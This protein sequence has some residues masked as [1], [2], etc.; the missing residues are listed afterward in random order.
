MNRETNEEIE[1]EEDEAKGGLRPAVIIRLLFY[2]AAM[3]ILAL[4]LTLNT[5]TGLG[6][7]AI[8]SISFAASEIWHLNFGDSTLVLYVILVLIQLVFHSLFFRRQI[9]EAGA[10]EVSA[11]YAR[12][13]E[14]LFKDVLEIPMSILFTRFLNLFAAVLPDVLSGEAGSFAA[15]LAG[16]LLILALAVSLT[17]IGAAM[18]LNMRLVPS[19]GDG[20]VQGAADFAAR[21]V[22]LMK[23]CVD[24]SCVVTAAALGLLADGRIVGIGVGTLCSMLFVGRVIAVFNR[25]FFAGMTAA[26]GVK[27]V[28]LEENSPEAEIKVTVKTGENGGINDCHNIK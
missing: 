18:S 16:R 3:N 13:R 7:S 5:K 14:I 11:V 12:R 19:A 4:G 25:F 23:N 20:V 22:G 27:P 1:T 17:G 21:P 6:V 9:R 24:A 15:S 2:A 10:D 28:S 26:A 8:V